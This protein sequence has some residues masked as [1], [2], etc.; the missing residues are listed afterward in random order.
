MTQPVR[1]VNISGWGRRSIERIRPGV[2]KAS[3]PQTGEVMVAQ[4]YIA[5]PIW[6]KAI[7]TKEAKFK[8][9]LYALFQ[10]HKVLDKFLN[11]EN[12]LVMTGTNLDEVYVLVK[13]ESNLQIILILRPFL[14]LT[15]NTHSCLHRY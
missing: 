11:V 14:E 9:Y 10:C 13:G 3:D 8:Q 5:K 6:S 2:A 1:L 4:I 15:F 7:P 12:K